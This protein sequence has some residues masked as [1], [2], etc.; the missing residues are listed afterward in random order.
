M[1]SSDLCHGDVLL[2]NWQAHQSI[3]E[4]GIRLITGS[5]FV[6]CAIVQ[7]VILGPYVRTILVLEQLQERRCEPVELYKPDPQ[8][9]IICMRPK[10]TPLP[11]NAA[12]VNHAGYNYWSIADS[13]I[14]H[15]LHRLTLK[16]WQFRPMLTKLKPDLYDCSQLVAKLLN[17]KLWQT[18]E[19]DDFFN[20]SAFDNL[21]IIEW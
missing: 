16:R 10:F 14:N 21:G 5:R 15:L 12:F 1:R 2:F 18:Q 19:P 20:N 13:L 8:C 11:F 9:S 17:D 3:Y 6:H 7:E 4:R